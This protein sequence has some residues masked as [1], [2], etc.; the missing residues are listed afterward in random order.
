MLRIQLLRSAA[1]LLLPV[2]LP[3]ESMNE[4]LARATAAVEAAAPRAQADPTRPI[5]HVTAP[6]QWINDPNGPI[7]HKGYYHLFYQLHPFSD[8]SGPKT[9]W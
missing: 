6:A 8:G 1:F 9:I 5:S 2:S 7:Y 3:A 4:A